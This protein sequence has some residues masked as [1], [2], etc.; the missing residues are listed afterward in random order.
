MCVADPK[1][2]TLISAVGFLHTAESDTTLRV[3]RVLNLRSVYVISENCGHQP[4]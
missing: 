2:Y 3:F 4:R 1:D